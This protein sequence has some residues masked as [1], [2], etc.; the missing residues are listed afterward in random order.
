MKRSLYS[1]R[2]TCHRDIGIVPLGHCSV[3]FN[4]FSKQRKTGT[5]TFTIK[6]CTPVKWVIYPWK[7]MAFA[8]IWRLT[9]C[10]F[11][12]TSL[13]RQKNPALKHSNE[14]IL[15]RQRHVAMDTHD[16]VI[17]NYP[18]IQSFMCSRFI[19]IHIGTAKWQLPNFGNRLLVHPV[20][21]E[22][23]WRNGRA[24]DREV[25]ETRLS[26]LVFPSSKKIN[27]KYKN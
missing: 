17:W 2:R 20:F 8:A 10:T 21:A 25:F 11:S 7:W 18:S 15:A 16:D 23:V 3:D 4:K 9:I 6:L 27:S 5:K 19:P 13:M 22:P 26:Q 1:F 24:W 14:V 12:L